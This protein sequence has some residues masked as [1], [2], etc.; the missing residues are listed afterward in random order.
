MDIFYS[1]F[2]KFAVA[3][4]IECLP[5]ILKDPSLIP[6]QEEFFLLEFLLKEEMNEMVNKK[7]NNNKNS[8]NSLVFGLWPQIIMAKQMH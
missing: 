5:V 1:R 3:Q 2:H 7:N 8:S 4:L 6:S